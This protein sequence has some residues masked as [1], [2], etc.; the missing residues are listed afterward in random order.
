MLQKPQDKKLISQ[1]VQCVGT[2]GP[3][4]PSVM[5]L[6]YPMSHGFS[7]PR[8][9]TSQRALLQSFSYLISCFCLVSFQLFIV[10]FY[11][12]SPWDSLHSPP[13]LY[14]LPSSLTRYISCP[15]THIPVNPTSKCFSTSPHRCL[16]SLKLYKSKSKPV[17]SPLCSKP[18]S[19][20]S[21]SVVTI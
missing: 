3:L 11:M 5:L 14:C 15:S 1:P 17:L 21:Q 9:H 6:R 18:A 20:A 19:S 12:S 13:C 7:L 8:G 2:T 16:T 4:L 10:Q